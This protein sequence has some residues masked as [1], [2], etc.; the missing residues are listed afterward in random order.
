MGELA[1]AK[2]AGFEPVGQVFGTTVVFLGRS[3]QAYPG[4]AGFGGC[5]VR[6]GDSGSGARTTADPRN[7]LIT[8][9]N[10]ARDRALERA[11]A[12]C[13]ALGG[14][15]IIGMRVN[16]AEFFTH[17]MEITVEGTAVRAHSPSRPATPFTTHVSGQDLARM[18]AAGWLPFALVFGTALAACHFDEAMFQQTRRGVGSVANREVAGYTR[19]VTDARREA[20]RTLEQAVRD[21][22]GEGAVIQETT[23]HFSER[24]CPRQFEQRADYVAEATILGS[25]I[26][27]IER[28]TPSRRPGPLTIMRFDERAETAMDAPEPDTLPK[29]SL[30]DRA[31]AYWAGRTTSA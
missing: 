11:V 14:D 8:A 17:T 2:G 28:S 10:S 24:E 20:R 1:A 30:G 5:F 21:R 27:S 9:L 18:L 13:E 16:S 31:I 25:A 23:L 19:I 29:L 26:I 15:G 12:E 6:E 22:G 7:P 4:P 3:G